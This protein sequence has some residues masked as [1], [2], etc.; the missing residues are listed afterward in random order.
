M[1]IFSNFPSFF[2]IYFINAQYFVKSFFKFI[3]K[4]S[5]FLQIEQ[6]S[7]RVRHYGGSLETVG[8]NGEERGM[9]RGKEKRQGEGAERRG[10]EKG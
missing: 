2:K 5:T 10:R 1:K 3:L 4:F 9:L 7:A 6:L 8:R